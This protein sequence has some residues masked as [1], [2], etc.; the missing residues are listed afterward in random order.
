MKHTNRQRPARNTLPGTLALAA[1]LAMS[2]TGVAH[3]AE[4]IT[5]TTAR[6]RLTP[7]QARGPIEVAAV[8]RLAHQ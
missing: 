3:A 5:T 2:A 4:T 1:T 7:E 6:A 8:E